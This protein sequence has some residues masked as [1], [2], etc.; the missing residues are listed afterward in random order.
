MEHGDSI[1]FANCWL[2]LSIRSV[3]IA[4]L[5]D[6]TIWLYSQ[7]VSSNYL[8]IFISFQWLS[9]QDIIFKTYFACVSSND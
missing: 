9:G 8:S 6:Q 1:S 4:N 2:Q 5:I 7:L 3:V